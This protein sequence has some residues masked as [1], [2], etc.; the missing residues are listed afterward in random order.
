MNRT[1]RLALVAP[2]AA[3]C[4]LAAG[5]SGGSSKPSAHASASAS[6]KG[7]V[8]PGEVTAT[9]SP[10]KAAQLAAEVRKFPG[11]S[12]TLYESKAHVLHVYFQPGVTDAEKLHAAVAIGARPS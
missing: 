12:T 2:L 9:M 4:L 1:M 10:S 8:L 3:A 5:C 7:A 6:T 11:V